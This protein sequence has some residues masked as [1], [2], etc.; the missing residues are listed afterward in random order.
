MNSLPVFMSAVTDHLWQSTLFA[1]MVA[2]LTLIFRRNSASIRYGLWLAASIKFL[3]PFSV[4]S[5][6]GARLYAEAGR[7]L[8]PGGNVPP[9]APDPLSA[10]ASMLNGVTAPLSSANPSGP[11]ALG[12]TSIGAPAD[13][14]VPLLLPALAGIWLLGSLSVAATWFVRWT[15]VRRALRSSK[16][17]GLEFVASVRV[18]SA[19]LEP[20]IVGIFRQTLLLPAGI[21]YYLNPAELQAVLAHERCHVQRKD[22]LTA[23]LHMLVETIFWFHPLVWW[24]GARLIEERE[25]ACDEQVLRGG[26][27]PE[28]YGEAILKICQHYVQARLA[29][30][31]TVSGAD[32][33]DRME[34]IMKNK[35]TKALSRS[36][37]LVLATAG[38]AAIAAPF[39]V[40]FLTAPQVRAQE[41]VNEASTGEYRN[42]SVQLATSERKP[43]FRFSY[44]PDLYLEAV[45]IK[46]LVATAW[47]V[48]EHQVF[49][50]RP[51]KDIQYD[52]TADGPL[53]SVPAPHPH[54]TAPMLRSLLKKQFGVVVQPERRDVDGYALLPDVSGLKMKASADDRHMSVLSFGYNAVQMRN[55]GLSPL[56][57]HLSNL[58]KVP[59]VDETGVTGRYDYALVWGPPRT[60][61]PGPDERVEP[62]V[63]IKAMK[64]QLGLHLEPRRTSVNV[65][66][67]VSSLP[68][69]QVVTPPR[70]DAPTVLSQ[71]EVDAL[72]GSWNGVVITEEN[73][74]I[75]ILRFSANERRELSGTYSVPHGIQEL[76]LANLRFSNGTLSFTVPGSREEF[77]GVLANDSVSGT[78]N[79]LGP[80]QVRFN[81]GEP[82]SPALAL[83]AE[84]FATLAGRW[85]GKEGIFDV[86]LAIEKDTKGR[87]TGYYENVDTKARVILGEASLTG[88][89]LAATGISAKLDI[90]ADVSGETLNGTYRMFDGPPTA[91]TLSRR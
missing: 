29:N 12:T 89:R 52:I 38:C 41:I 65:M 2:A 20:G 36:R 8:T 85:T 78:W 60:E 48:P 42:V 33:R 63:I 86:V 57:N 31:A 79:W 46:S 51:E 84:S 44:S 61:P 22:N 34:G 91:F 66:N 25:R 6:L 81:K 27:A 28:S 72:A 73:Q 10:V 9:L 58:L 50:S 5:A 76:P 26:H 90:V 30:V 39:A 64:E 15:R 21:E 62:A 54:P 24:L 7:F 17:A 35:L 16:P 77:V 23:A 3:V 68:T 49:D 18:S 4:F 11:G 74:F 69:A 53:L 67:V 83:S 70:K 1:L 75:A 71:A 14:L 55:V 87:Y 59:V 47:E 32:L 80:V 88:R 82:E 37:K 40:G 43:G 45:T 19:P 13:S 56:A